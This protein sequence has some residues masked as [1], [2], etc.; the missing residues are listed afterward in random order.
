VAVG[1]YLDRL[2]PEVA[3]WLPKVNN[4]GNNV[5]LN[6]TLSRIGGQKGQV[7]GTEAICRL[8]GCKD[9]QGLTAALQSKG[10]GRQVKSW[11]STDQNQQ[12]TAAD[13]KKA[14]DP[15]VLRTM[16]K[17]QEMSPDELSDH[18]ARALPHLIEQAS[19]DGTVSQQG[20]VPQ[21]GAGTVKDGATKGTN[22]VKSAPRK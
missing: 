3:K 8:F 17:E 15:A 6:E 2:T 22:N 13:I 9:L 20:T 18:V 10:L 21:Q 12:V 11:I 19:Q 7:G 16:A 14:A 4:G 1:K 5:N